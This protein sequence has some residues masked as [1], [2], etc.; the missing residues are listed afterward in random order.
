MNIEAMLRD[1][2][3]DNILFSDN[4]YP[5]PDEASFFDEGIVDSTGIMELVLFIEEVFGL[6]IETKDLLPENFGSVSKLAAYIRRRLYQADP[7]G[8]GG[9]Y[10]TP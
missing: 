6:S 10:V 9:F 8:R 5:Y 3:V 1:Y 2:I 7:V 4:G